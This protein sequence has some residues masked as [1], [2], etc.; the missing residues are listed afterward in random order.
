MRPELVAKIKD[1]V[2][3]GAI[4]YGPAPDH[5][6]SLK[7]YPEADVTVKKLA[8]E[9]WGD[10]DGVT[11]KSHKYGK[12]MIINGMD[13]K[14]ALAMVG[15]QPDCQVGP[16][17]VNYGHR[18]AGNAD[19]YFLT[20]QSAGQT[21]TVNPEFRV[22][23]MQPELWLP[24][25]GEIRPLPAYEQ[26]AT[27]TKVPLKLAPNESAF[28]VFRHAA[29]K[30]VSDDLSRNYP[31]PVTIAAIKGPWLVTFENT[32]FGPESPVKLDTLYDLS[33]SVVDK[34]K[35]YSGDMTYTAAFSIGKLMPGSDIVLNLSAVGNMAK[36]KINGQYA[37]GVWTPPYELNISKLV[38]KGKNTIEVQ[39]VNTWVN[40]L[41]GDSKLPVEQR[42][43][44]TVH[45]PEPGVTLQKSGLI[46]PVTIQRV[47]R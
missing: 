30:A 27:T 43:T 12:G 31:D 16:V 2:R 40:R 47:S 42:S 17:A 33:T 18:K 25:T 36:V 14:E 41:L 28:I 9:L 44:W 46:G 23:G 26:T 15:S 8:E 11:I 22:A 45:Y 32:K 13:L 6:P 19:I 35:Y 38:K 29:G 3:N 39:V 34:I 37:G 7:G 21:V 24:T 10:V 20:N 1:L 4:V 5:S